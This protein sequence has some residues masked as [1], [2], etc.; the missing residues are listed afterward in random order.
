MAAPDRGG[1]IYPIDVQDQFSETIAKFRAELESAKQAFKQFQR[2]T[3]GRGRGGGAGGGTRAKAQLSDEERQAKKL[4]RARQNLID[5]RVVDA[6]L[7]REGLRQKRVAIG[8]LSAE[9]AAQRKVTQAIRNQAIARQQLAQLRAAGR[10]DLITP[11]LLRRAGE[12]EQTVKRTNS[13]SRQLLFTFRRLVGT[14]AVFTLAREAF[15]GAAGLVSGG[16]SFNDQIRSAQ[17]SIGG[18]VATVFD[19]RDAQGQSVEGAERLAAAQGL[20]AEQTAQLRQDA[21][22]TT[23]TF[24]QLLSTF[25]VAVAPGARAGLNLD[26]IRALTVQISQAATAIGVPQNQLAEE[27]RSL[28]SGT[29]QARTTRIA[30]ALGITNED[31]RN[32]RETGELFDFLSSRF[33]VFADAAELQARSTLAG[34]SALINGATRGLLGEAAQ[35]LFD[36]LLSLGNDFF[37]RVLTIQDAAGNIIPNPQAV[38]AFEG[39]FN[40]L[41]RGV[42]AAR[43]LATEVGFEG[44][45]DIVDSIATGLITG[46]ELAVGFARALVAALR[47]GAGAVRALS[48]FFGVSVSDLG[49]LA[50][51]SGILLGVFT[52]LKL[53]IGALSVPVIAVGAGLLAAAKFAQ[54]LATRLTGIDLTVSQTLR[55]GIIGVV[56][57]FD[58]LLTTVQLLAI[59]LQGLSPG[60]ALSEGASK[61]TTL[62]DGALASLGNEAAA[63][64]LAADATRDIAEAG[65]G[66][67]DVAE[68]AAEAVRKEAEERRRLRSELA[69]GII[70]SGGDDDDEGGS[71]I[72]GVLAGLL[73]IEGASK[74]IASNVNQVITELQA[75]LESARRTL[76]QAQDQFQIQVGQGEVADIGGRLRQN[77]DQQAL[78][79]A[80]NLRQARLELSKI[81]A[82]I[83]PLV[84]AQVNGFALSAEQSQKLNSLLN[85]Q[86]QLQGALA[87]AE[88]QSA[89]IVAA[90]AA[91]IANEVLPALREEQRLREIQSVAEAGLIA[92]R[93]QNATDAQLAVLRARQARVEFEAQVQRETTQLREQLRITRE[94]AAAATDPTQQAALSALFQQLQKEVGTRKEIVD[95]QRDALAF[96]EERARLAAE[97]S[98]AEGLREGLNVLVNELPNAFELG[99]Q[100]VRNLTEGTSAFIAQEIANAFDPTVQTSFEERLGRFLLTLTQQF[101]Q[102]LIQQQI[103]LGLAALLNKQAEATVEQS[104]A[105]LAATIKINA[106]TTAANIEIAAAQTAAAIRAAGGGVGGAHQGGLV[107]PQ[108]FHRGGRVRAGASPKPAHFTSKAL[109]RMFGGGPPPGIHPMDTV[110]AWL[111]AGEFVMRKSAVDQLGVPFLSA[112]NA[113]TMGVPP[114]AAATGGGGASAAGGGMQSGGMVQAPRTRRASRGGT[115]VL[116]A[117]V[118]RERE[119]NTLLRGGRR[120]VRRN[121]RENAGNIQTITNRDRL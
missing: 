84:L 4:A 108:G 40:A 41:A 63:A 94:Q 61:L 26:Q 14:L 66:R 99:L 55:L 112:L 103:Q 72:R 58:D 96:E 106:A 81:E 87:I 45:K 2:E 25:Q 97:G 57:L 111:Q 76:S 113:G 43:E 12:F 38:A 27:I 54:L 92:A 18:L 29:I 10:D 116:P 60:E 86:R 15:Q 71:N 30:T 36:Q 48:D 46:F 67:V 44:L 64:R 47:L 3:G 22:R 53:V 114:A 83:V 109:S 62:I 110:P 24:D 93:R 13:S 120:S 70:T 59:E 69:A 77:V 80:E 35:P 79:D 51:I 11:A 34:I 9:A 104:A 82:G 42:V 37:D 85:D 117:I 1:L 17:T 20:A 8:Q 73:G 33:S 89:A 90:R 16:V 107:K 5:K 91:T 105:Q 74:T 52:T 102:Q 7:E 21:L 50:A 88:A 100:T 49:A 115:V 98:F 19:L 6:Q 28:L 78:V 95:S 56:Q 32:L 65:S 75:G 39:L 118:A 121:H 119:M 23:A 31:I 68:K 101:F